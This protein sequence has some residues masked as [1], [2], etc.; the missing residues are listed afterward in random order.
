[1]RRHPHQ[2]QDT[3][4]GI[5]FIT[6]LSPWLSLGLIDYSNLIWLEFL[7]PVYLLNVWTNV[8]TNFCGLPMLPCP[9]EG[10]IVICGP[11]S[12]SFWP[13]SLQGLHLLVSWIRLSCCQNICHY[14]SHLFNQL[15]AFS[16]YCFV[17]L[18]SFKLYHPYFLDEMIIFHSLHEVNCFLRSHLFFFLLG[19]VSVQASNI[20]I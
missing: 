16:C 8:W 17:S 15:N 1:M 12:V 18:W 10:A 9:L 7:N 20:F 6:L 14:Y 2:C 3:K 5:V 19:F 4:C 13:Y 11:K